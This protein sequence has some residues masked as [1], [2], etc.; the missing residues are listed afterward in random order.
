VTLSEYLKREPRGTLT[1]LYRESGL[2]MH[3]LNALKRGGT[4]EDFSKAKA[5]S[6]A[7]GW[8]VPVAVLWGPAARGEARPEDLEPAPRAA[9]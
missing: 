8:D 7:T 3:T 9:G 5:A 1:R 6:K 4:V 2:S